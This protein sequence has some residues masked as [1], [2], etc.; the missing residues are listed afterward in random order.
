MRKVLLTG[1]REAADVEGAYGDIASIAG[2]IYQNG[3]I[4]FGEREIG[5]VIGGGKIS[6]KSMKAAQV[7]QIHENTSFQN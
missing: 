2:V 7:M 4:A 3:R 6:Q 1:G 5:A